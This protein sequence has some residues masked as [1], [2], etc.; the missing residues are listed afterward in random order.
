[1]ENI[2]VEV[3]YFPNIC[4]KPKKEQVCNV[5]SRFLFCPLEASFSINTWAAILN[6]FFF[7]VIIKATNSL[8]LSIPYYTLSRISGE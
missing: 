1:M 7:R 6:L 4:R 3:L 8:L 2:S 5:F